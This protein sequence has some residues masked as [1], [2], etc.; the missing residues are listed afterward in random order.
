MSS[1]KFAAEAEKIL[2]L[3]ISHRVH[4]LGGYG[5]NGEVIYEKHPFSCPSVLVDKRE[6][7]AAV[8]MSNGSMGF[9]VTRRDGR[10]IHVLRPHFDQFEKRETGVPSHN[11]WISAGDNRYA[12]LINHAAAGSGLLPERMKLVKL[13]D[14][15]RAFWYC[16]EFSAG[17]GVRFE[18]AVRCALAVTEA[19]PA[20][21]R[22][23]FFLNN[24]SG[25]FEGSLWAFF[26]VRGIQFFTYNKDIW[27]DM[28]L[29]VSPADTVVAA[30]VPY[31]DIVQI[32]RI[33]SLTEGDI[34]PGP[35][36]CDYV[37]FIGHS[38]SCS[39]LPEAVR[40]GSLLNRG[41]EEK[42]NRFS[43]PT[44]Y[45]QEFA[46][47]IEPGEHGCLEQSLLYITDEETAQ[48][49][50]SRMQSGVP[51]YT[52]M[53]ESFRKASLYLCGATPGIEEIE[54][55]GERKGS[56][57]PH[58][59]FLYLLPSIPTVQEY[60]NSVWTGVEELYENCRAHGAQLAQGIELGTRDRA[61]DM[62]PKM[63]QD[64]ARVRQDLVHI[65]SFMYF[66]TEEDIDGKK[67]LTLTEK[68][69]GMFPRQYPSRWTDR[70]EKVF[71]DNRPYADSALW[72]ID[73]L[74]M[75]IRETGDASILLEP[76][77]T[78]KLVDP[79]DPIRSA[80]TGHD[81]T[82]HITEV[83]CEILASFERHA[84]TSPY[85]MAQV[86]YGDWCDPVDMF[87]TNPACD[88]DTRGRG[89]GVNTRLSAHVFMKA[90]HAADL[91]ETEP[92][93]SLLKKDLAD[94]DARI[95]RMK[96]FADRLRQNIAA[97]AWEES[98]TGTSGFTDYIHEFKKD[99]SVP[100]YGKGEAG[101]TL[102]S[103]EGKDFDGRN[104]RV[105]TAQA[106]GL[107][108]LAA[109][110]DYLTPVEKS[111]EKT[112]AL[113]KTV[114]NLFYDEKLGLKLLSVP[115]ANN[116]ETL[117]YAGRIGI[118]PAGTA[119]NGEYHHGQAMM[120]LFRLDLPD[121]ADTVWE[122]FS[123]IM[124]AVRD[125]DLNGPF[126]TPSTSYASDP[127]DPHFG[128]G[129]YFGL[130]GSTDWIIEIFEKIAGLE[131]NLHDNTQPSVSVNPKLPN[132]IDKQLTYKRVIH[133]ALPEGGYREIPFRL[134]IDKA[135]GKKQPGITVNGSRVVRAEVADLENVGRVDI[136][137]IL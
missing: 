93:R 130:S 80:M 124:S 3:E 123:P 54:K 89:R 42:F 16:S 85:G 36:T 29:P 92:V 91:F 136:E 35:A 120:H 75:Y 39:L 53:A 55:L 4:S 84:D 31:S 15:E 65:F 87:G 119:E 24:G 137:I 112:E 7:A 83:V 13:G 129:M 109:D 70:N 103:M 11:V 14:P 78:V 121:Q 82:L 63:K 37:S 108:M 105:L 76:V 40:T 61:Q 27:Y 135:G 126:E 115:V 66:H 102:G 60:A 73:S 125:E 88:A 96:E 68:I 45:A 111:S 67:E 114:R 79:E 51:A 99:G 21:T 8:F 28:G 131:L 71:N 59:Y 116:E 128:A 2:N 113:L 86:M 110:R 133:Y 118:L 74:L 132:V 72:P 94:I 19:G 134:T 23:I 104:R 97:H 100:D 33:S 56:G 17:N 81:T 41:A 30:T 20:I 122:Q 43:T 57:P 46:V 44:I 38:A 1:K 117:R 32:K 12:S 10:E 50:R 18:T 9:T 48:E 69:H 98:G 64:P 6:N 95:V 52:D 25:M 22:Q 58:P 49:F 107:R 26:N 47:S 77:K 62:W 34:V 5:P 127:D 101:Y 106:W 90:V